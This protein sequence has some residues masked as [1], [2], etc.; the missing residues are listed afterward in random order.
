MSHFALHAVWLW[1]LSHIGSFL[2]CLCMSRHFS[3]CMHVL[4]FARA[5]ECGLGLVSGSHQHMP[6]TALWGPAFIPR[7]FHSPTFAIG[8]QKMFS[9]VFAFQQKRK[10]KKN[11][12]IYFY[13]HLDCGLSFDTRH[14][15]IMQHGPKKICSTS[16]PALTHS[17]T[18]DKQ[19]NWRWSFIKHIFPHPSL[20]SEF[21]ISLG[22]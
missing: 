4:L 7:C 16:S 19:T 10:K 9:Q 21:Y 5:G 2:G 6:D 11:A 8:A 3:A 15:S 12:S 22:H 17:G 13:T 20:I 18:R 14:F 1:V